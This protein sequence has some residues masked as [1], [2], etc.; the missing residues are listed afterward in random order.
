M[1]AFSFNIRSNSYKEYNIDK[2]KIPFVLCLLNSS[3]F[4]LIWTIISDGWH[5]TNKEL[6][7]IK[8]P[9]RI[10]KPQRWIELQKEL[11]TKLEET[12]VYVG[13]KQTQYEYKHR[14]CLEEIHA[15]DDFINAAYGLTESESEYIKTFA[16]RYR[17]SGGIDADESN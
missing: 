5:I 11:E 1:K 7:F 6:S 14:D 12:K 2:L 13:T 16:I 17:T 10:P 9:H 8:I 15:I 4:F 3:L